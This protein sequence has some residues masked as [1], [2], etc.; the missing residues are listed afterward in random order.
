MRLHIHLLQMTFEN[1]LTKGEIACKLCGRR[2]NLLITSNTSICQK[3]SAADFLKVGKGE[4]LYQNNLKKSAADDFEIILSKNVIEWITYDLKWKTLWQNE[5]LLVLSNFFF[6]HY[7]FK[8]PSA[9]E[10]P[11]SVYMRETVNI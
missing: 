10:A 8:K 7:V 4:I 1:F 11:E 2:S 6:C 3:L 5:K 9:A